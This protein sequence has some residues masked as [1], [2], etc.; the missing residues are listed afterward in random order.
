MTKIDIAALRNNY[1]DA[2]IDA[3]TLPEEP[4][5]MFSNWFH[6]ALEAEIAE[7][8]GMVIATASDLGCISQRTVL[9]KFFDHSGFFFYTNYGSRKASQLN[10]NP[11]ISCLFPWY[12]LHRQV[13][14]QGVVSK[15]TRVNSEQYFS[16]RPRGSQIGAWASIQSAPLDHREVL[17]QRVT[18]LSDE[19]RNKEIPKPPFWG[20]YHVQPL[21]V[22]FWQGRTSRLH[23]R[24]VYSRENI[25]SEDWRIERLYP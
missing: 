18:Q 15:A 7:P 12:S 8:N 20:G 9:M 11:A 23:D 3:D 21:R 13:A 2:G 25:D 19:Y 17:E 5:T 14:F 10:A 1:S 16:S 6:Q 4:F 24:I 22:E